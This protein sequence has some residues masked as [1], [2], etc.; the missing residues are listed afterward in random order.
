VFAFAHGMTILDL[1]N[2]FPEDADLDAA[3]LRGLNALRG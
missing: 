1:D 3:W 2:R